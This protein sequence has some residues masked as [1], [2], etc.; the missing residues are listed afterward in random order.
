MICEKCKK[1]FSDKK[2]EHKITYEGIDFHHS[3]PKFMLDVWEGKIIN[4]CREHHKELHKDII[5]IMFK[6]ST[7]FKPLKSEHWT[8]VKIIPCDRK[9]CI[10]EIIK[11]TD[12]WLNDNS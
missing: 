9:D 2:W 3:P 11:F 4:L 6:Y 5:K 1:D 12:D 7:L 8:W 10:K